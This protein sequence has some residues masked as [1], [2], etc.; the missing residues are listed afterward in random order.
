M[1][2]IVIGTFSK[3]LH[4]RNDSSVS[5]LKQTSGQND[6]MK[7]SRNF[8]INIIFIF[9]VHSQQFMFVNQKRHNQKETKEIDRH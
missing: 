5:I 8:V 3:I 4:R 2:I 7:A 9:E 6:A 1:N